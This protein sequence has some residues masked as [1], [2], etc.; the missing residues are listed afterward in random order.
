LANETIR[1]Q[2]RLEMEANDVDAPPCLI[3]PPSSTGAELETG[4]G[5]VSSLL[6][7]RAALARALSLDD[8]DDDLAAILQLEE[9]EKRESADMASED[10]DAHSA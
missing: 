8:N 5:L 4:R 1:E 10:A 7:I 3:S 6:A 9:D 2:E